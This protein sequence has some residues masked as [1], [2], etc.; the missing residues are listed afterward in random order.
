MPCRTFLLLQLLVVVIYS[1]LLFQFFF[2]PNKNV[3]SGY[4]SPHNSSNFLNICHFTLISPYFFHCLPYHVYVLA[5]HYA[6]VST[7]N[8]YHYTSS[9]GLKIL[10]V[11]KQKHFNVWMFMESVIIIPSNLLNFF[12]VCY[13]LKFPIQTYISYIS[14][15][16]YDICKFSVL[17]LSEVGI[18]TFL[19]ELQLKVLY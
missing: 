3:Q 13:F 4:N 9:K 17:K 18:V 12:F 19:G 8:I 2:S 5:L 1:H 16:I 7:V 14:N 11:Q 15:S 6:L 10:I